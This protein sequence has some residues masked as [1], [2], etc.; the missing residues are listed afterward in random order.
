MDIKMYDKSYYL[1]NRE[2]YYKSSKKYQQSKKGKLSLKK[3]RKSEKGKLNQK[4][5]IQS[6]KGKIST[7][8]I[9]I[10]LGKKYRFKYS[11]KIKARNFINNLLQNSN[12]T[13]DMCCIFGKPDAEFHHENY[14]LPNFGY[15]FCV[16]HHKEI[17]KGVL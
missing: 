11:E 1:K 13:R 8:K 2:K 14:D 7:K 10:K 9:Y 17:H 16:K 5:Y 15:W 3:Y 12:F 6:N 4:K